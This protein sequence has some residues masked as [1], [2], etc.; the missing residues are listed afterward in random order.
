MNISTL[1]KYRKFIKRFKVPR[2]PITGNFLMKNLK[3]S[4]NLKLT[5]Y[6][7]KELITDTFGNRSA[8][9]GCPICRFRRFKGPAA[10]PH[11]DECRYHAVWRPWLFNTKYR[12]LCCELDD[13]SVCHKGRGCRSCTR[14]AWGHLLAICIDFS[15]IHG[16]NRSLLRHS[17]DAL[18]PVPYPGAPCSPRRP[19]R[20]LCPH[21]RKTTAIR[22]ALPR[23]ATQMPLSSPLTRHLQRSKWVMLR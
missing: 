8:R 15:E 3:N 21:L 5:R 18:C 17:E 13:C 14:M 22:P 7:I 2:F 23:C 12:Y 19:F 9:R 6:L 16:Y 20:S 10:T 1:K 11:P 4:L